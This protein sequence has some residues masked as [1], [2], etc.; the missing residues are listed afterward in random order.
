VDGAGAP[1]GGG[2]GGGPGGDGT[3]DGQRRIA[4]P[5]PK[6]ESVAKVS[7]EA[8]VK[9]QVRVDYPDELRTLEIQG[10]VRLE[11]VVDE[12]GKVIY[13]AVKKGLHPDLDA[14]AEKA[15]WNLEFEPAIKDDL[16]VKTTIPYTFTFVLE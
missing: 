7:R 11:L 3:G 16:P 13:V 2:P 10:R 12:N 6:T 1:G 14:L 4:K 5:K 15:A 8:K 9:K